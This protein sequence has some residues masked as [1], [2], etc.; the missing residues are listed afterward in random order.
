MVSRDIVGKCLW[1]LLGTLAVAGTAW[2]L[3]A[4][5]AGNVGRGT[6]KASKPAAVSAPAE[7][8]GHRPATL[9]RR[10]ASA[11]AGTLLT[12]SPESASPDARAAERELFRLQ[13]ENQRLRAELD[14]CKA[15]KESYRKQ[16]NELEQ[17][18]ATLKLTEAFMAGGTEPSIA[19][20]RIDKTIDIAL[21]SN[22]RSDRAFRTW[23]LP[24]KDENA[25]I[26]KARMC[27][28]ER[29]GND[30]DLEVNLNFFMALYIWDSK[31]YAGIINDGLEWIK[32]NSAS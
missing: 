4:L 30:Y 32:D 17:E 1:T 28:L 7:T 23:I 20:E 3:S 22:K 21:S 15:E 27:A 18:I 26:K 13:S 10:D 31:K 25:I 24:E 14:T 12:S 8:T 16:I 2:G 9:V 6:P 11:T 5:V 29:W 19:K